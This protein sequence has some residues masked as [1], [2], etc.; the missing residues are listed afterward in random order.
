MWKY[1][2]VEMKKIAL[3]GY[4]INKSGPSERCSSGRASG[5][6]WYND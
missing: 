2:N 1:E 3:Y 6:F 4:D 5:I